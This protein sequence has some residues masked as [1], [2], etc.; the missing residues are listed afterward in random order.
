MSIFG[1]ISVENHRGERKRIVQKR[2]VRDDYEQLPRRD[3]GGRVRRY[4]QPNGRISRQVEAAEPG[5]L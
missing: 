4:V 2:A 1:D 3:P 5:H